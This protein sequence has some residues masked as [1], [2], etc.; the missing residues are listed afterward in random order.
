MRRALLFAI[1]ITG[2]SGSVETSSGEPP[3]A[4]CEPGERWTQLASPPAAV[5]GGNATAAWTGSTLV[6]FG[7]GTDQSHA[8]GAVLNPRSN[9]WTT[10]APVPGSQG[11]RS[12]GDPNFGLSS[13]AAAGHFVAWGGF[14]GKSPFYGGNNLDLDTLTWRSVSLV[15]APQGDLTMSVLAA[16]SNVIVFGGDNPLCGSAAGG[17]SYDPVSDV[18]T[19]LPIE[20]EPPPRTSPLAVWTGS[21][22]IVWGGDGSS[23]L[24]DTGGIYDPSAR[25]WTPTST[26][27]APS[28]REW[29]GA[30]WTGSTMIVWGSTPC[31]AP[32][33]SG[34][35][36]Y[37][38]STDSWKAI[39]EV[40]APPPGTQP[41]L[42]W[43]GSKMG[44]L[45]THTLY[46]PATDQW[47]P[48]TTVG[49]PPPG[50]ADAELLF[51]A[52][53]GCRAILEGT[54]PDLEVQVWAYT[55]PP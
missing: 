25:T 42:V 33:G 54:G 18:W 30:V 40:G 8:L 5:A 45:F 32:P 24:L 17:A 19:P 7:D 16:N 3:A 4:W 22:M 52:W 31:G 55:P 9:A 27:G 34:G 41:I 49:A 39:S 35:G 14:L 51:G 48:M 21:T 6:V 37:D 20:G 12:W 43:L 1:A 2:C 13:S 53:D 36:I 44:E 26:A 50:G 15:D 23:G 28:P 10:T 29:Y 47:T 46:D 38:P 11:T